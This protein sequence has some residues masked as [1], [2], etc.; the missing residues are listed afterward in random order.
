MYFSSSMMFKTEKSLSGFSI[1]IIAKSLIGS[2]A[3]TL[4]SYSFQSFV[5]TVYFAFAS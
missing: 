2:K 4:E 3:I 5:I 1:F